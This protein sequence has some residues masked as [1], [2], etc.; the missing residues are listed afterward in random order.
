MA[1]VRDGKGVSMR[2]VIHPHARER[3][4][5]RGATREEIIATL[6][7]GERFAAKL[8]RTGFRRNFSFHGTWRGRVYATKQLE[9]FAVEQR[10]QWLVIT[11]IARYF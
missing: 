1:A 4:Q 10:N 11:V 5:E 7:E 8:G 9:V 6:Q 2:V 3:M